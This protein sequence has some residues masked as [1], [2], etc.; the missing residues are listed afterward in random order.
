ME[1]SKCGI[2]ENTTLKVRLFPNGNE[3]LCPYCLLQYWVTTWQ[4]ESS[5]LI[6][7][8]VARVKKDYNEQIS[9]MVE[10]N[11]KTTEMLMRKINDLVQKQKGDKDDKG[12]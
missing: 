2:D 7:E 1:C 9:K 11:I 4:S 12:K 3:W 8:A 6:A 5:H 10:E